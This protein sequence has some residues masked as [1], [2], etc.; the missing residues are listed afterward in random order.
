MSL[1]PA[2][3]SNNLTNSAV[4]SLGRDVDGNF[5][6]GSYDFFDIFYKATPAPTYSYTAVEAATN[7]VSYNI[8]FDYNYTGAPAN[9]VRPTGTTGK[10]SALPTIP[11]REGYTF[12]GWFNA[13]T[14][15]TEITVDTTFTANATV[16]ARWTQDNPLLNGI[17]FKDVDVL[18]TD[19]R[20]EWSIQNNL[21]NGDKIFGCYRD[22]TFAGLPDR[23]KGLEWLRPSGNSKAPQT[24]VATF[25]AGQYMD[26][27]IALD[28]RVA[29]QHGLPAWLESYE[30]TELTAATKDA[31]GLDIVFEI[32]KRTF[33]KGANITL[34]T[35]GPTYGVMMYAVFAKAIDHIIISWASVNEGWLELS[36]PTNRD[37]SCKGLFLSNSE[38][39]YEWQI[40]ALI[41]PAGETVR[42]LD[43]GNTQDAI[44]KR[45][46]T[47]FD[48]EA[49]GETLTLTTASG[50]ILW[51]YQVD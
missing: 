49:S 13:R 32:Y 25:T 4:Y 1:K 33:T 12:T 6:N 51:S 19:N 9:L 21:Q 45:M 2:D 8:T 36:N 42:V 5:F 41:I 24:D 34:G 20:E 39:K 14:G 37:L 40:P 23:L 43:V 38:D 7:P 11:T 44:P 3:I 27:Y 15:G 26:L 22:F 10:L 48:I 28:S 30:K 47:N 35:N 31:Q 17:L 46:Q 29:K 50:V 18:D 16:Y